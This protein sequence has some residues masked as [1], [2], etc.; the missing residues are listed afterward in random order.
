ML[1]FCIPQATLLLL[2]IYISHE[3]KSHITPFI[4]IH[5]TDESTP[6]TSFISQCFTF[7][8]IQMNQPV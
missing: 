6:P 3:L 8:H 7:I 5:A 1:G 2:L 4:N